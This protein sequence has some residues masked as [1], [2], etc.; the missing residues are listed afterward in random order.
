MKRSEKVQI[1][2]SSLMGT[3]EGREKN[4]LIV[5]GMCSNEHEK[6]K[7]FLEFQIE[8]RK[9]LLEQERKQ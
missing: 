5:E 7:K 3:S 4:K 2:F 1:S 8:M 9:R 6:N